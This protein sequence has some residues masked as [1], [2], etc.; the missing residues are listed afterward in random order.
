VNITTTALHLERMDSTHYDNISDYYANST[1]NPTSNQNYFSTGDT[2]AWWTKAILQVFAPF[3]IIGNG[4]TIIVIVKY[5]RLR[6]YTNAFVASLAAAD[7]LVGAIFVP[8]IGFR[9]M[10]DGDELFKIKYYCLF[11][12]GPYHYTLSLQL[13][14]LL[15]ISVDRFIAIVY[16]YRYFLF[17][18]WQVITGILLVIWI[19]P[20]IG[21]ICFMT[22]WNT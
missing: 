16:P 3:M 13:F 11:N 20:L 4:L 2:I 19:G 12:V 15:A 7:L 22:V 10:E 1:I 14:S 17:A 21:T 9:L 8:F 18:R 5:R 6:T